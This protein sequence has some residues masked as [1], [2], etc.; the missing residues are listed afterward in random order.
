MQITSELLYRMIYD[1]IECK[2]IY[3][4]NL[5]NQL[6]ENIETTKNLIEKFHNK[7]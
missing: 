7:A 1:H 6:S 2:G 3:P 5:I 4:I